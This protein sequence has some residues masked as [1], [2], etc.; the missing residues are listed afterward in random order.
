VQEKRAAAGEGAGAAG[1]A[2]A[3]VCEGGGDE[4]HAL[5]GGGSLGAAPA[6]QRAAALRSESVNFISL[7]P[8]K[9]GVFGDDSLAGRGHAVRGGGWGGAGGRVRGLPLAGGLERPGGKEGTQ[10]SSFPFE[11]LTGAHFVHHSA[12]SR[13]PFAF[14]SLC[15]VCPC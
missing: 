9:G 8:P 11:T 13:S 10:K 7:H 12:V 4:G 1:G 15:C 2:G 6:R 14:L 5:G 3:W